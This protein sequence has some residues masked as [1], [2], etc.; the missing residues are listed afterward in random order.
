MK[1]RKTTVALLLT[2]ALG[3]LPFAVLAQAPAKAPAPAAAPAPQAPE[4]KTAVATAPGAAMAVQTVKLSATIVGIDAATRTVTLKGQ[5][6]KVFDLVAG[7]EVKNFAQ[8][9]VGD[10]VS[11]QYTQALTLE[12]K[13]AGAA[14][15]AAMGEQT[16]VKRA[17]EGAKPGGTVAR[18][19]TILADVVAVDAKKKLVTLK[20]PRGNTV[21]LDVQDPEQLKNIKKG[22]KVEAVYTEALAV[23]V[24]AVPAAP[25][26]KEPAKKEPAKK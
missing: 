17:P 15:G 5:Q 4:V 11:A 13:K 1:T 19:V 20:G 14:T 6:G 9:K 10:K 12:L 24:E 23:S 16:A 25:A 18:Q 8:L 22:D 3:A 7:D 21:D 26:K 2:A